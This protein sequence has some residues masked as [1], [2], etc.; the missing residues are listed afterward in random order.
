MPVSRRRSGRRAAASWARFALLLVITAVL[1]GPV[2]VIV[3]RALTGFDP[4]TGAA[5]ISL[6]GFTT[7]LGGDALVWFGNS[8]GVSAATVVVSVVLAAPAGYVL[9][10]AR[11]RWV[12]GY[13]LVIFALQSLP[14]VVFIVPLFIVFARLGLIDDLAGLTII[15]IGSALAVAIWMI[16]AATDAVPVLIE[17]AAWLD[18][19]SVAGAYL[20]IVLPNLRPAIASAAILVFLQAWNEYFVAL[21][22]LR[23]DQNKTL[24]VVLAGSHSPVLAVVMALPPVLLALVLNRYLRVP[25][26]AVP[27][28]S[29]LA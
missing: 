11:G 22:F 25:G 4:R 17:E 23:S 10:R 9:S 16:A 14:A 26:A 13:A 15:Y 2:G 27:H 28:R 8:L 19:C 18:G 21:V 7:L 20:R 6:R 29:R 5:V 12:S 1:L 24:A 3:G